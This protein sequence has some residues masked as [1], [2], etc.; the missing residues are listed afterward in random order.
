VGSDAPNVG[1]A[2]LGRPQA[3]AEAARALQLAAR[4]LAVEPTAVRAA[5]YRTFRAAQGDAGLPSS[6]A[7]SLLF[8]GWQRA[9][10]HAA[11]LTFDE[12]AVEAEVVRTL[13]GDPS[14]RQRVHGTCVDVS[15][16]RVGTT[17]P[18]MGR[19]ARRG[20]VV[21]GA[22]DVSCAPNDGTGPKSDAWVNA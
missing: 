5:A 16:A 12:V 9:C 11:A 15:R 3:R 10:E 13:Y 4:W 14:C 2:T 22:A 8:T 17:I 18:P 19:G 7:I 6:L 21:S 1:A 20:D